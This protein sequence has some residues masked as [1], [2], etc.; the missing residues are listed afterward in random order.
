[1][2]NNPF[3][4]D[5][6]K[7]KKSLFQKK[8]INISFKNVKQVE[9]IEQR[10]K[11]LIEFGNHKIAPEQIKFVYD[12]EQQL[13]HDV[14]K[15]FK[16]GGGRVYSVA[17]AKGS[18][19]NT[20]LKKVDRLGNIISLDFNHFN[21]LMLPPSIEELTELAELDFR[22]SAVTEIPD[23]LQKLPKLKSLNLQNTK[24]L[25]PEQ[26]TKL[27]AIFPFALI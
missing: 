13:L 7:A 4:P 2:Y 6:Q 24:N 25:S 20:I 3:T 5:S 17:Q 15:I 22:N 10:L 19:D 18:I 8:V 12:L 27:K 26:K 14:N 21:L 16:R 11:S 9:L 23:A 1:M